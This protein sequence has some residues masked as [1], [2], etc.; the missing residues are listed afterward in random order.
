MIPRPRWLPR[1]SAVL[2]VLAPA[3][4]TLAISLPR[5]CPTI[6]AVGDSIEMV[7]VAAVHGVAHAPG[8]PL[9]AILVGWFARLPLMDLPWRVNV[10][11]ALLHGVTVA[12]VAATVLTLTRSALAAVTGSLAL[13]LSKAFALASLYAEVFPLNDL[14]FA[15]L[16]L[17]A[18]LLWRERSAATSPRARR[19][20]VGLAFASGLASANQQTIVLS[21]PA[22][23]IL[24]SVPCARA[25]SPRP[26][27]LLGLFFLF[28]LPIVVSY[29]CLW[30]AA[31]HH[32]PVSWGDIH[33]L[34]SL[35]R[36]FARS[37]YWEHF[38]RQP[39]RAWDGL[40][41]RGAQFGSLLYASV[42]PVVLLVAALGL[43]LHFRRDRVEAV[44]LGLAFLVSGPLFAL[45]TPLFGAS[46]PAAIAV[47]ERFVAM[48]LVPLSLLVGCG[49]GGAETWLRRLLGSGWVVSSI[50]AAAFTV[51]R[52]GGAL[53]I[54]LRADRRGL[55][56]AHD[57]VDGTP[58][59][60]LVLVTGDVYVQA[61]TYVCAV[62]QACGHRVL[63]AP[64]ALHSAW[65]R[66]ELARRYPEIAAELGDD[67][68][69]ASAH[70][71]VS[72]E[73]ARRPVL[74]MSDFLLKDRQLG[75][76]ALA[77]DL[78]LLRL[79]P[80]Q[81]AAG[82]DLPR[83]AARMRALAAGTG[84]DG[85]DLFASGYEP[86]EELLLRQAYSSAIANAATAARALLGDEALSAALRARATRIGG[87]E[88]DGT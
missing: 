77:P 40:D 57:L 15:S 73:L 42:G 76:L 16:L 37:D 64:G 26:V 75:E 50:L 60:A 27:R 61:S 3:L 80:S 58:D 32:P 22:L 19:L 4:I 71:L 31:A 56:F 63:L 39:V 46:S 5:V 74:A 24:A 2:A 45:I 29:G 1:A 84:C 81:A 55:A 86:R 82:A 59:D 67:P 18:V 51:P 87:A 85:C 43:V 21:A 70:V 72:R 12:V 33:D 35:F 23:A 38:Q 14:F 8:F 9:Y 69:I 79:Y 88:E 65:Q 10:S 28:L 30:R 68:G 52:I 36:L 49:V 78:L 41:L 47:V 54:D 34:R 62:E 25:V 83:V 44:A 53:R 48:P 11:S 66:A 20:L 7:T 6:V 13:A 17:L